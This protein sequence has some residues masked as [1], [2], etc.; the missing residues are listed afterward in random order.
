MSTKKIF[1]SYGHDSSDKVLRIKQDLEQNGYTVWLDTEGIRPGDDWRAKITEAILKCDIV[2]AF[3]SQH[4]LRKD[5]VCLNELA[6]AVSHKPGAVKTVLLQNG[7]ED[8]IPGTVSWIQFCDMGEWEQY[9]H[10][11]EEEFNSWYDG[12]LNEVIAAIERGADRDRD[13]QIK[14]LEQTL[15]PALSSSRRDIELQKPYVNRIWMEQKVNDWLASSDSSQYLLMY[16]GP[17]TGKSAF[18]AHYF[19]FDSRTAGSVFCEWGCRNYSDAAQVI[20]SIA[21]QI[22]LKFPTYRMRLA[23]IIENCGRNLATYSVQELFDLL[24]LKPLYGDTAGDR[25]ILVIIDGVDEANEFSSNELAEVLSEYG[26]RVPPFLKILITSRND[27]IVQR[28]FSDCE[29]LHIDIHTAENSSDIFRYLQ[30]QLKDMTASFPAWRREQIIK[31]LAKKSGSSFLYAEL[32]VK[33]ICS[34]SIPVDR[35][36]QVPKG[37]NGMYFNWMKRKFPDEIQYETEFSS[38]LSLIAAAGQLP[39]KMLDKTLGLRGTKLSR[40]MRRM[41]TFLET[42]KNLLGEECVYF[43]H[44]SFAEWLCS[45]N[46]DIY[47]L[48]VEEGMHRLAEKM[49]ISYINGDMTDFEA[50]FL[51]EYLQNCNMLGEYQDASSDQGYLRRLYELGKTYESAVGGFE[52]AAGIYEK[53]ENLLKDR[54]MD[55]REIQEL[56]Y[57]SLCGRGRCLFAM[58]DY[59]GAFEVLD[60]EKENIFR[61]VAANEQMQALMVLAS[62]S[63]WKGNRE[64]AAEL[65]HELLGLS[66][67]ENSS[68]YMLRSYA[69]LIWNDHFNDVKQA[70]ERLRIVSEMELSESEKMTCNLC[71]ARILLSEGKLSEA[72]ECYDNCFREFDSSI[73]DDFYT[74]KKNKMLMLEILPACFDNERYLDGIRYGLKIWGHVRN[75]GWLEE[76]YC[77]SWIALNYL[78]MGNM[79]AA[80]QYLYHAQACNNT[81][82]D[83]RSSWMEMHLTSVEAFLHFEKEEYTE[84]VNTHTKVLELASKCNDA[85]VQGDTCFELLAILL[86]FAPEIG[87]RCSDMTDELER[88]LKKVCD[89]SGLIHLQ[90][91]YM[92]IKAVRKAYAGEH[93]AVRMTEEARK[94]SDNYRLAS[95]DPIEM[96]YIEYSVSSMI[97]SESKDEICRRIYSTISEINDLNRPEDQAQRI[98][99]PLLKLI[100]RKVF[101]NEGEC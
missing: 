31:E 10:L 28:Y 90:C 101:R 37:L 55:T 92:M 81:V 21:F 66:Y 71:I 48:D 84:A 85:W 12:K 5:S 91:K 86:V 57:S 13:L 62:A 96:L 58:G 2:L 18:S 53:I 77:A 64:Q 45:E 70:E 47:E 80:E 63:D 79:E 69:G 56:R 35:P 36:E 25:T 9:A 87:I 97:E 61:F 8:K 7:I 43:F 49:Y 40:F 27:S 34:G 95:I 16:G 23:G 98:E 41:K 74:L 20:K 93:E 24:L 89:S 11:S 99:R 42:E 60:V 54:Y 30:D 15:S 1:F 59:V 29:E 3:L 72:L 65:F 73:Y 51:L 19:H 14:Y 44:R 4:S 22:A 82:T 6:I 26:N 94:L 17:G 67:R 38:A 75:Q 52:S 39:V 76:C 33:A 100:K 50:E 83:V 68:H 32:L 78:R 88:E 46:S